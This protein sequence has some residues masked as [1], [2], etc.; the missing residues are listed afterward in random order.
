MV[1]DDLS[2]KQKVAL[3]ITLPTSLFLLYLLFRKREE[4][5]YEKPS[6]DLATGQFL[7][8]EMKIPAKMVGTVI[9]REGAK[10]KQ[11]QEESGARVRFQGESG[12]KEEEDRVVIIRGSP[13]NAMM[14]EQ[15]L[16]KCISEQPVIDTVE[17]YLPQRAIG[18]I[19]G[20]GG[21]NIRLISRS[22]KAKVFIERTDGKRDPNSKR[23]CYIK[24]TVDQ[25]KC[26]QAMIQEE[27]EQE[28]E[29]QRQLES[30]AAN[31]RQRKPAR[32]SDSNAMNA[33]PVQPTPGP[34]PNHNTK[35]QESPSSPTTTNL[36]QLPSHPNFFTVY[37]SAVEHPGHF[38]FQ[39]IT[40]K[41]RHFD[42]LVE[43]MT[44][45]YRQRENQ[46][47]YRAADG[48][49]TGDIVAAP[50]QGDE[51]WYRARILDFLEDNKVDLY[52]VDYGDCG[53]VPRSDVLSIKTDFLGMPF[54]A[55]EASL[56]GAKP[57]DTE[58]SEAACDFFE[59]S[60]YCA[61][62]KPVMARIVS[63]SQPSL[64]QQPCV[65]LIDTN[66]TTD[67]NMLEELIKKGYAEAT[68]VP[69][70][71]KSPV[72]QRQKQAPPSPSRTMGSP[73]RHMGSPSKPKNAP[74]PGG[75]YPS[76]YGGT[77]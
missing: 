51:L 42:L 50:F 70:A 20:R 64:M 74:S 62:W 7:M 55:I 43:Q 52:Y 26:A 56:S 16:N 21:E 3:A 71:P 75:D 11:I 17:I 30:A 6:N 15:L 57:T 10:I 73:N 12:L 41:A 31:R 37:V 1:L 66:G 2:T 27:I 23:L 68:A 5:E 47:K 22:S 24:G 18:R 61:Q 59:D 46:E 28:E 58:W 44:E 13:E 39:I 14:A 32:Q 34:T 29:Y 49:S 9:G 63:Y 8:I 72:N 60:T 36:M 48:L 19:I 76:S 38:W 54:Q 40:P 33:T 53:Q 65:E 35:E 25:I 69:K 45:F 4:E 77:G 67:K